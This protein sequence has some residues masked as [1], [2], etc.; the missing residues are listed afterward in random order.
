M[1]GATVAGA[2]GGLRLK[3]TPKDAEVFVDG[4]YVGLVDDFD[5]V[6]HHLNLTAGPHHIDVHAPGYDAFGLDVIIQPHHTTEYQ[7][8]LQPA[9]R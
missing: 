5:G 6:F 7:G 9:T 2:T 3:I 4:G 8:G 1:V